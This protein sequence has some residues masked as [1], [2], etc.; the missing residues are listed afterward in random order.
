[1]SI[2][3]ANIKFY[4]GKNRKKVWLKRLKNMD[5]Q[6]IELKKD[7]FTVQDYNALLKSKKFYERCL[8]FY[9]ISLLA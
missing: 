7:N 6:I 5:I 1:L 8:H 9:G 2:K 4:C 3:N